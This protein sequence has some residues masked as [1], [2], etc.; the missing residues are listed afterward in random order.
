RY[1][2]D[3]TGPPK[4]TLPHL[5]EFPEIVWPSVIKT[6][7]NWILA[8]LI[9]TPYFDQEF[10]LPDFISGSK[11][12]I[13]SKTSNSITT[14]DYGSL[15][16]LVTL[17]ALQEV[18]K[19]VASFSVQQ[20]QELAILKDDIYFSFPYQ[21]GVMFSDEDKNQQR[22]VEITMCYHVLRGLKEMTQQGVSPP[23][24]MG[25]LPEY[26]DKIFICNYRFIREFTKG[27]ED[28][29]TV[30]VINHFKPADYTS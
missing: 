25:M 28:Q 11:Q 22:F 7:R 30:N 17:E 3:D 27:V 29:W 26:R 5:M 8:N 20:R 21:I 9:I 14:G 18:K 15:D 10:R 23:L 1:Y 24:N 4:R 6:L 12:V 13:N 19:S 2:S 16:N